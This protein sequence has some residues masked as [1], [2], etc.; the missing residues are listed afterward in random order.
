MPRLRAAD[1]LALLSRPRRR[2]SGDEQRS[3]RWSVEPRDDRWERAIDA[4]D[5]ERDCLEI[6]TILSNHLFPLDILIAT[7]LAQLRTF[8]IPTISN[9][10]HQTGEYERRGGKRLD[11]TKAILAEILGAGMD[12][13][14]GAAMVAHLNAIHG[15]Y[16]ISNDDFLYTLSVFTVDVDAWIERWGWRPLRPIERRAL[17]RIY[18]DLGE[19][20][21]IREI[22]PTFAG[23]V[24]WREAYEARVRRYDPDNEAV[25]RA[26]IDGL[27][28][29]A[30]KA[31][32]A[33]SPTI[34]ALLSDASVR[35]LGLPRPPPAVTAAVHLTLELRRQ[36]LRRLTIWN[37]K[38]FWDTALF[39]HYPTYPAGYERL[40]LGPA[41]IVAA[42]E[43]QAAAKT[44]TAHRSADA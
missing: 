40:R 14:E 37:H 34:R 38:R 30:G 15:H 23:M 9:L 29:L 7:E 25:A 20:M 2:D 24:A 28:A 1:L 32:P 6:V 31:G 18:R 3:S 35:A 33:V 8:T 44:T 11:D 5:P 22:P 39:N 19:R 27:T 41:K 17:Y 43:R 4:L 26:L 36:L 16:R 10:L 21:G 42:L 13:P 12:T